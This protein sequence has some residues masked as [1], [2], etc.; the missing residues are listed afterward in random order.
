MK[1]IIPL[2]LLLFISLSPVSAK[3]I[4]FSVDMDTITINATGIHVFGDFQAIA[5]FPNGD[6]QSNT[7]PMTQVGTSSV[8]TV[9]VDVPAFVKYEYK[10][11][12]GDQ[13]YEVEFVPDQARVGYNFNDNR[14]VF[15]DSL[16]DD[17]TDIPAV[18]FSEN[19]P[20]GLELMRFYVDMQSILISP[21]GVH[22]AGDFQGWDPAATRMYSFGGTLYEIIAY[23]SVGTY[24]YRFYNGNIASDSEIVP[25]P[26]M[27]NFN[28]ELQVSYDTLVPIVCFAFCTACPTGIPENEFS[29]GISLYPNPA[30]QEATLNFDEP[31]KA[32]V[33]LFDLAGRAVLRAN[34]DGENS[35]RLNCGNLEAGTYFIHVLSGTSGMPAVRKLIIQ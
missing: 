2:L 27:V 3:K 15:V 6:W 28:R 22:I 24:Q 9:I 7:T 8:Y 20:A 30:S 16:A 1:K 5:G 21:S 14:W 4:R 29:S 17:T 25:A 23:D 19:A 35:L 13:S 31:V 11:I 12:N 26:C 10:F 33:S 32:T 18:V 34:V